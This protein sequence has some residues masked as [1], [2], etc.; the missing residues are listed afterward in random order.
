M[1]GMPRQRENLI[2]HE[3]QNGQT[4]RKPH[5]Y[6]NNFQTFPAAFVT[7]WFSFGLKYVKTKAAFQN[8]ETPLVI[9]ETPSLQ[10]EI[11]PLALDCQI[12]FEFF[13]MPLSVTFTSR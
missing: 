9:F 10:P 4:A 2:T 5:E 6:V 3:I 7:V 8:F 1:I 11:G 13:M 12:F